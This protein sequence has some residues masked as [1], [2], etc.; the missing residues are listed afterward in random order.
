MQTSKIVFFLNG[1][2][3]E[4]E[5][6]P[7]KTLLEVL[8]ENYKIYGT[9][10][11]CNEGDCGACTVAISNV[12]DNDSSIKYMSVNSCI[13][14]AEKINNRHIITVE[15]IS[16]DP[17]RLHYIQ[18]LL[19]MN[20]GT[21][22]GYCT[23][24]IIMSIFCYLA[25]NKDLDIEGLTRSLEG[26]LCRCTG[27]AHII[28]GCE[29]IISYFRVNQNSIIPRNIK[30]IESLLKQTQDEKYSVV[31]SDS[32]VKGYY[33]VKSIDKYLEVVSKLPVLDSRKIISG[34]TDLYV[35]ANLKKEYYKHYLD[36]SAI[37]ELNHLAINGNI[38]E[39]GAAKSL[40]DVKNS[41]L[42][43]ENL[44]ILSKVLAK[45]ASLQIRNVASIG[46]NIGNASP[47][48]DVA[49]ALLG[50]NAKLMIIGPRGTREILLDDFYKGYKEIE[51]NNTEIIAQILVD[52]SE[53]R[54]NHFIKSSKREVLDISSV[55]SLISIKHLDG[56]IEEMRLA[57][58]GVAAYPIISKVA[59]QFKGIL[60]NDN[61]I[62]ELAIEVAEEFKPLSDVRG[63][64]EFRK[65][66]IRNHLIKHLLTFKEEVIN[67]K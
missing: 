34:G 61:S 60:E 67:E 2:K 53:N 26:N 43:T 32:S 50:L 7:G 46:G 8:Q 11:V 56:E 41:S 63:D 44:P 30:H 65:V 42:V 27:Y 48:G 4:L 58:G 14:P 6:V 36:V 5:L 64:A 54:F 15:G 40:E 51:L 1:E 33:R 49:T 62:E 66:L 24:G 45:M 22:C 20:H 37:P 23:P 38:L 19:F 13:F 10:S 3:R 16:D 21:Q 35:V 28:K 39:I 9:K 31:D 12:S 47:V 55:F 57:Y 52:L 59:L 25:S 18:R 29:A 17:N